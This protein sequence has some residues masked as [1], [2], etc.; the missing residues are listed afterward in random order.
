MT[1]V[2]VKYVP[3]EHS[4][5]AERAIH[6]LWQNYATAG[7]GGSILHRAAESTLNTMVRMHESAIE[8]SQIN[9]G[10]VAIVVLP[11]HRRDYWETSIWDLAVSENVEW[12]RYAN[13]DV[14]EAAKALA[15]W[16][17]ANPWGDPR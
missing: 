9:N 10:E 3:R 17:D 2:R 14:W 11:D 15:E 6:G 13:E 7:M 5:A 16:W 12:S 4:A 1:N 8:F